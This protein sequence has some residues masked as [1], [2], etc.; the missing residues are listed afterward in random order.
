MD[1]P[2]CWDI[3][4]D[5]LVPKITL[6][7]LSLFFVT[8]SPLSHSDLFCQNDPCDI[9][10]SYTNGGELTANQAIITFGEGASI[11]LGESGSYDLGLSGYIYDSDITDLDTHID[12]P[13]GTKVYLGAG[14]KLVFSN[15]GY[16]HLGNGGN[17]ENLGESE[18]QLN[19]VTTIENSSNSTL[20]LAP[21]SNEHAD[22]TFIASNSIV[23]DS[24]L[25]SHFKVKSDEVTIQSYDLN[26]AAP[27]PFEAKTLNF[28]V[29]NGEIQLGT[30][31]PSNVEASTISLADLTLTNGPTITIS[32][33]S[34][35]VDKVPCSIQFVENDLATLSGNIV[36]NGDDDPI[37][38]GIDNLT[39]GD[40]QNP[41]LNDNDCGDSD[42]SCNGASFTF[43]VEDCNT[44]DQLMEYTDAT[45]AY[46]IESEVTIAYVHASQRLQM[47]TAEIEN[48]DSPTDEQLAALAEA[49]EAY[50]EA[51]KAFSDFSERYNNNE[52]YISEDEQILRVLCSELELAQKEKDESEGGGSTFWLL[53]LTLLLSTRRSRACTLLQRMN[54]I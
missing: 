44:Q 14:A 6:L 3:N 42:G 12:I 15:E 54:V 31:I 26:V 53:S 51:E 32:D 38:I 13:A 17:I 11:E 33:S 9:K 39:V 35:T 40:D 47:I 22:Y 2:T 25:S 10:L 45:D 8:L 46:L 36:V 4:K 30:Q 41:L 52:I 7:A 29:S 18:T 34:C 21:S 20:L 43:N 5:I 48:T 37:S 24:T 23:W 19:G 16:M 50:I 28:I 49:E 27:E 1:T